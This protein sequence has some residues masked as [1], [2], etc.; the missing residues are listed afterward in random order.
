MRIFSGASMSGE[1]FYGTVH[2]LLTMCLDK[3]QRMVVFVRILPM[4]GYSG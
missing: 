4:A 3:F 2:T 1:M